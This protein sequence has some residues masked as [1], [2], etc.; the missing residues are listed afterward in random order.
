[1]VCPLKPFHLAYQSREY[2]AVYPPDIPLLFAFLVVRK[3]KVVLLSDR[4]EQLIL[5]VRHVYY[6]LCGPFHISGVG[7][8]TLPGQ[9]PTRV[10]LYLPPPPL[11]HVFLFLELHLLLGLLRQLLRRLLLLCR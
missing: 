8:Q 5:R 4:L 6:Q 7:I 1:M 9:F 3:Q 10:V 2:L 11:L